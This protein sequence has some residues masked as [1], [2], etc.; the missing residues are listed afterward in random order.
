MSEKPV[1]VF[2]THNRKKAAELVDLLVG[3]GVE[4][5]TLAD[6]PDAIEIEESASSF[7]ENAAIK[8]TRQAAH[9]GRWVLADD[10]GLVVD[11]L[12]GAPGIYSARYAGEHA[13]DA[14]NRRKLLAQLAQV[15]QPERRTA[16]FACH[17]ALADPRGSVRAEAS[18]RCH[19]RIRHADAGSG[20]FGYDPLFEIVEYHRTFG[21][22]GAAVKACISHR[23]RA[24]AA[25]V[26][27]I[28]ELL[29]SG[30]WNDRG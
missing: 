5:R 6:F 22:L 17:L 2:G 28:A 25:I 20:G 30:V 18:G 29:E 11:A 1:L 7:A 14:D 3:L 23:A 9:L 15:A 10:S 24:M 21:E 12:G 16:Y 19:G 4:L 27:R 8:A 26:P 13:T